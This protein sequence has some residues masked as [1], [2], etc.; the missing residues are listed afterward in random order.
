MHA[1]IDSFEEKKIDGGKNNVVFY[2]MIVG[3]SKNNKKWFIMKRYSDFD[4]LQK[5]V[6]DIYPNLPV[7]PAK[8]FFK[9]SDQKYI[10]ERRKTLNSYIKA[11][12]NRKDMR[13]C[14]AFR[15]FIALEEHFP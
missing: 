10:E 7:L 15:K 1:S 11:L 8:T 3:F 12:V 13:T 14:S 4:A 5:Q 6:K 2:K 9:L